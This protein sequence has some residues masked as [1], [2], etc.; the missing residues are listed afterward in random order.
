M[1]EVKDNKNAYLALFVLAV[2]SYLY[3]TGFF[4][5]PNKKEKSKENPKN[6]VDRLAEINNLFNEY[7][8]Y[9]NNLCVIR[10]VRNK[11]LRENTVNNAEILTAIDKEIE[12]NRLKAREKELAHSS[13]FTDLINR[14]P[15]IAMKHITEILKKMKE[16]IKIDFEFYHDVP[17][18]GLILKYNEFEKIYNESY[19]N[20]LKKNPSLIH[21]FKKHSDKT[22]I[23]NDHNIFKNITSIENAMIKCQI[24]NSDGRCA[25]FSFNNG[26]MMSYIST[27]GI[28][29]ISETGKDIYTWQ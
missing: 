27:D 28:S 16:N 18:E 12:K 23:S 11:T 7:L 10:L 20:L 19:N 22:I 26:E 8:A 3:Y 5:K 4:K 9:A 25:A 13:Y 15:I 21:N 6:N 2:L 14:N 17:E 29:L 1:S 24:E